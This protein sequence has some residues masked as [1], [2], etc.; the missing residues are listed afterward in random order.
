[1]PSARYTEYRVGEPDID[2]TDDVAKSKIVAFF[3]LDVER[4]EGATPEMQRAI[5][6][7]EEHLQH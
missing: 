6:D 3:A 5:R 7:M 4:S 2:V 1:M